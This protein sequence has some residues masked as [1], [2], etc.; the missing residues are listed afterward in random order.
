MAPF[1]G[2]TAEKISRA[3]EQTPPP[4]LPTNSAGLT[5]E[6]PRLV[7]KALE[8]DRAQR[9]LNM[10]QM[11]ESLKQLRRNVELEAQAFSKWRWAAALA[12]T[13]LILAAAIFLLTHHKTDEA[14]AMR[15]LRSIAVLPFESRNGKEAERYFAEGIGDELVNQLS[16]IAELKVISNSS[17]DRYRA[18]NTESGR[19]RTAAWGSVFARGVSAKEWR[20]GAAGGPA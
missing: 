3:I 16:R 12:G 20:T 2:N 15:E 17:T 7:L 6:F 14:P 4:A 8:K 11:L 13:A 5:A 1:S 10:S 18:S 9:Y 19:Y